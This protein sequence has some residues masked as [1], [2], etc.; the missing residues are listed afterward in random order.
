MREV[1]ADV[2]AATAKQK[3]LQQLLQQE[4]QEA[5]KVVREVHADVVVAAASQPLGSGVGSALLRSLS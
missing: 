5:E 1:H 2:V 4:L 3:D